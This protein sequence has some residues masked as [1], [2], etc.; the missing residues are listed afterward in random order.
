MRAAHSSGASIVY[1]NVRAIKILA[2]AESS[3]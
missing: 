2:A 3:T 1:T